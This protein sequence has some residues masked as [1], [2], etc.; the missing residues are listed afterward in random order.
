MMV[1]ILVVQ[2]G[3]PQSLDPILGFAVTLN[4]DPGAFLDQGRVILDLNFQLRQTLRPLKMKMQLWFLLS[5]LEWMTL[6]Q[7]FLASSRLVD[8]TFWGL[9]QKALD[10]F[11][12]KVVWGPSLQSF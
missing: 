1:E 3:W 5:R 11:H 7:T 2:A 9:V 6:L 4:Q 12:Q 8:H 10:P